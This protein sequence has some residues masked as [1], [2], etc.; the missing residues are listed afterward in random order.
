MFST[1]LIKIKK[2]QNKISTLAMIFT[3]DA[4]SA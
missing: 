4:N 3:L 1:I 2:N